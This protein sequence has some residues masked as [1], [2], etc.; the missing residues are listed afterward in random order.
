MK[1]KICGMKYPENMIA[2]ADLQPNYLGFIFHEK[3]PRFLNDK[4]PTLPDDI[5]KT[6]VFV[7]VSE[8]FIVKKVEE[9]K[10]AAIQLHGEESPGFCSALKSKLSSRAQSGDLTLIKVFSIKDD[11]NFDVLKPYE[12]IADYFL[13]D[14]KGQLPGGNGYTFDWSILK[15]YPS[16]TP[17]FLSGGIGIDEVEKIVE[18]SNTDLPVYAIDVNSRFEIAPGQKN[19]EQLKEFKNKLSGLLKHR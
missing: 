1:L 14:T 8:E 18:I 9:Y 6:G 10:L 4:I 7:N 19:I 2:V 15:G 5:I 11:F 13:F 16:K 3:S 12:K 17:F